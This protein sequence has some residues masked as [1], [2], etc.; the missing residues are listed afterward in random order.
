ML[1]GAKTGGY[2]GSEEEEVHQPRSHLSNTLYKA[3][4]IYAKAR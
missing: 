2:A 4:L 3:L 1:G